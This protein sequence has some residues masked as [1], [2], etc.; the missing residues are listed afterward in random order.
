MELAFLKDYWQQLIA[1]ITLIV[2][3]VRLSASVK[4]LRKDV[5]DI[6]ARNT[7]VETTRLTA[8]ITVHEKQISALWQYV[9]KLRDMFTNGGSK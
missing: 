8:Q 9:N 1:I 5:D 3:A 2:V 7:F 4:E 6:I